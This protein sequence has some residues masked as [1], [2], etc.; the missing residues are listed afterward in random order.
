MYQRLQCT[1]NYFFKIKFV[2]FLYLLLSASW[3]E[4]DLSWYISVIRQ[5]VV[6]R[7]PVFTLPFSWRLHITITYNLQH[8]WLWYVDVTVIAYTPEV[9]CLTFQTSRHEKDGTRSESTWFE[10]S[11]LIPWIWNFCTFL[12][13]VNSERILSR[14]NISTFTVF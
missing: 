2:L 7:T 3:K 11:V 14:V 9:V 6:Y 4:N 13:N 8:L 1:D 10:T 12:W 5:T